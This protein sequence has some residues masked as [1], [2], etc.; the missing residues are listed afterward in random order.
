MQTRAVRH[1]PM[2][3]FARR[4]SRSSRATDS[5]REP[6]RF[7]RST[8]RRK[9]QRLLG[10]Q[11]DGARDQGLVSMFLWGVLRAKN[12]RTPLYTYYW[13]HAMPGPDR[14]VY[15]AFHT[16][17]V[18]YV[19]NTL[20]RSHRPW[21][22]ADRAIAQTMSTYWTN[23]V[24]SGDPNGPGLTSWPAFGRGGLVTMELGDHFGTRAVADAAQF[25]FFSKYF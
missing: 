15:R 22:P 12:S 13:D 4:N 18:P 10:S 23:F 9:T 8:R 11:I 14:E 24:T 7:F 17:E 6:M 16:S 1:P 5:A 25:E 19:F 20:N 2:E 3:R 21:Q